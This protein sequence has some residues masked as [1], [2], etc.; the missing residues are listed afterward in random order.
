MYFLR[1]VKKYFYFYLKNLKSTKNNYQPQNKQ[2]CPLNQSFWK[3]KEIYQP[4]HKPA[5]NRKQTTKSRHSNIRAQPNYLTRTKMGIY[6]LL[7]EVHFGVSPWG[8][9]GVSGMKTPLPKLSNCAELLIL[10][11]MV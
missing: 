6:K 5:L 2:K 9:G 3:N 4:I 10:H 11:S 1:F 7:P 8:W